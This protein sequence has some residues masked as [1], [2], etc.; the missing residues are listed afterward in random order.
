M[1][2]GVQHPL[3][4]FST[5]AGVAAAMTARQLYLQSTTCQASLLCKAYAEYHMAYGWQ[6][7]V[8]FFSLIWHDECYSGSTSSQP[9]QPEYYLWL[10]DRALFLVS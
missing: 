10:Q 7:Y 8:P 3:G 4:V 1:I 5:L 9:C 2:L 6:L